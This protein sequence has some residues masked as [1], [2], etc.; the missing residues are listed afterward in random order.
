MLKH[1]IIHVSHVQKS[2][3]SKE[4]QLSIQ[5]QGC[6]ETG[7]YTLQGA[8]K[9]HSYTVVYTSTKGLAHYVTHSISLLRSIALRA[10]KDSNTYICIIL[11]CTYLE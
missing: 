6:G 9:L 3:A 10:Y 2:I 11:T 1:N 8:I 5:V 7:L 4:F